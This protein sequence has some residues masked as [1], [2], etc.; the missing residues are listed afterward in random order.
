[1]KTFAY[2]IVAYNNYTE[3][4]IKHYELTVLKE[5]TA[6]VQNKTIFRGKITKTQAKELMAQGVEVAA[7]YSI[8]GM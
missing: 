1:M 4:K 2:L 8:T 3:R 7:G 5:I 6:M